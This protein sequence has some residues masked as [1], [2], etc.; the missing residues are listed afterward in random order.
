MWI[1]F[2]NG[3]IN[4]DNFQD[5]GFYRFAPCDYRVYF[6]NSDANIF[7]SFKTEPE[8]KAR[9]NE[10]KNLLLRAPE[11]YDEVEGEALPF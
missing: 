11:T 8:A 6:A 1:E 5:V 10:I 3:L 9:Y 4:S 2:A 7:E